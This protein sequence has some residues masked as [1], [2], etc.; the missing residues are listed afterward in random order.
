M[1]HPFESLAKKESKF[2]APFRTQPFCFLGIH[3]AH[4]APA[5]SFAVALGQSAGRVHQRGPRSHQS[6]SRPNHRQIRL[7]S[8]AAMLYRTQQLGSILAKGSAH[9][10]RMHPG[11]QT[12]SGSEACPQTL[13][14][15]PSE[16]CSIAVPAI[17]CPPHPTRS[18]S[19]TDPPDLNPMVS[20]C[21][22]NS[23][24]VLLLRR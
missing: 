22:E 23:C 5:Q 20:F 12:Q 21:W 1:E 15:W 8:R 17:R 10:R 18:T 16:L 13:P 7:R 4:I 11:L 9:P 2:Q 6:G 3:I 24:S 19:S 14:S